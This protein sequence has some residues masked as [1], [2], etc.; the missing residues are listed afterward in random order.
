[1]PKKIRFKSVKEFM[2]EDE[3]TY[4]EAMEKYQEQIDYFK[5]L[6]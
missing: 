1:M 6:D 4:D 5:D 3:L 2:I